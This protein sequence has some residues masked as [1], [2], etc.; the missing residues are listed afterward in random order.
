MTEGVPGLLLYLGL[1][2]VGYTVWSYAGL[3]WLGRGGSWSRALARGVGR[4]VLGWATG[5]AIAPFALVATGT[6]HMN[7]FYFMVLPVVRWLEWGIIQVTISPT[8]QGAAFIHGLSPRG[9]LWRLGGIVV[10][11]LADLPFLLAGGLPQG[12]I[13]C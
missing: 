13:F 12:R 10:S 1:K 8:R 9:R 6:G 11:Y 2:L 4:L 7:G 3:V 5:L